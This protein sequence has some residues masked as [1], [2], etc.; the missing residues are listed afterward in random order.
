MLGVV[1]PS[2]ISTDPR[3]EP[4]VLLVDDHGPSLL[5]LH[6]LLESVGYACVSSE[7]PAEALALCDHRR[8]AVIVTDL[9]MPRIDGH[10]LA[11]AVGSRY[12]GL[13][14]LLVTGNMLDLTTQRAY[15]QTFAGVFFKPIEV[16]PFLA[17]LGR[18]LPPSSASPTGP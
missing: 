3:P 12:P 9:D 16:E 15:R 13:P 2:L 1:T 18:F 7:S 10:G 8:P 17:T 11:R 14:I 4:F 5:R 6:A